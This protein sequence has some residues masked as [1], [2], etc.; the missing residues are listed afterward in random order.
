MSE[1]TT[2][3][4]DIDEVDSKVEEQFDQAGSESEIVQ[5]ANHLIKLF[6]NIHRLKNAEIDSH[7]LTLVGNLVIPLCNENNIEVLANLL[8]MHIGTLKLPERV[9]IT[10]DNLA[11]LMNVMARNTTITKL[12]ISFNNI[13]NVGI[14]LFAIHL[15]RNNTLKM[16]DLSYNQ[17]TDTGVILL[18]ASLS[19]NN[20]IIVV[21]LSGNNITEIGKS[22]LDAVR[23]I[24][25]TL[26]IYFF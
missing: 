17:I 10:N 11:T 24:R 16:L 12:V 6:A 20:S 18:A 2:I 25:P 23:I 1:V 21:D 9:G 14:G 15:S 3:D 7:V 5:T 13:G 4:N 8:N 26:Q 22:S 19:K